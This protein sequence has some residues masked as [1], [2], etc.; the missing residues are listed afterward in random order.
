MARK[1]KNIDVFRHIDMQNGPLWTD[2][3]TGEVSR[4][5]P[6]TG[7]LNSEGRPYITINGKK[8]LAYRVVYEAVTGEELG[9]R[10]FR[11]KCDNQICCNYKHGIPGDHTQNMDDMKQRERHGMSHHMVKYV[12]RMINK[13]L[14]NDVIHEM[15]GV[16]RTSIQ[17]I[18]DGTNY[19]HVKLDNEGNE[20]DQ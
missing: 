14:S 12:K 2:P 10:M 8:Q 1:N 11:H 17:Y 20:D 18:R 13:G 6:F 7:A 19:S 16:S 3:E 15:T 5:W 9:D 4:C